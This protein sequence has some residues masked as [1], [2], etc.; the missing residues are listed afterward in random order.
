MQLDFGRPP[1]L[2][3]PIEAAIRL[4]TV[5]PHLKVWVISD[6]SEA[7][8]RLPTAYQDGW[9]SFEIGTQPPYN[10]STIYYL[11]RL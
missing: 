6:K 11:I 2:I 9:L 8:T 1:I 7:V 5:H 10:P 4:R 3:E